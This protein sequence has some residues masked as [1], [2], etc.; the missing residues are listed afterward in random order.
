MMSC[1]MLQQRDLSMLLDDICVVTPLREMHQSVYLS[2]EPT[3]FDLYFQG[4]YGELHQYSLFTLTL[5]IFATD[6]SRKNGITTTISTQ[7]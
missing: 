1:S 3:A 2:H 6:F 5:T 7:R 4:T